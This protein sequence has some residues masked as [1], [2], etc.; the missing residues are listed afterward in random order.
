MCVPAVFPFLEHFVNI[1]VMT[2][3][4]VNYNYFISVSV[5]FHQTVSYCG[6]ALNLLRTSEAQSF[7]ERIDFSTEALLKGRSLRFESSS[8]PL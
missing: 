8:F 2:L 5:H 6:L 1:S 4:M 3:F 7:A